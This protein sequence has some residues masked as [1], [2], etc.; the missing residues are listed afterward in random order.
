MTSCKN[1]AHKLETNDNINW[2]TLKIE[3]RSQTI[4]IDRYEEYGIRD[5]CDFEEV[6]I[7]KS[8]VQYRPINRGQEYFKITQQEKDSLFKYVYDIVTNPVCT[9]QFATCYVGNI[10]IGF[11]MINTTRI[12]KYNSVGN[13]TTISPSMYRLYSLLNEKTK[14]PE[15]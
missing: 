4:I 3:S 15:Y 8:S 2:E 12:C 9:E 5:T 7:D 14:I 11:S 6:E 10:S 13:W 1:N